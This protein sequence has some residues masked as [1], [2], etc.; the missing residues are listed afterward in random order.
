VKA[1]WRGMEG[2]ACEGERRQ[3]QDIKLAGW[4]LQK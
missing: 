4:L 3:R 1:A 2:G